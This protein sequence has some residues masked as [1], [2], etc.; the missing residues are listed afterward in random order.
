MEMLDEYLT[1]QK[2]DSDAKSFSQD[3]FIEMMYKMGQRNIIL[4]SQIIAGDMA[5]ILYVASIM[6]ADDTCYKWMQNEEPQLS[7][8][9]FDRLSLNYLYNKL[10]EM[11]DG[12]YYNTL[13]NVLITSG[14]LQEDV[15]QQCLTAF[16]QGQF[17]LCACGLLTIIEG[18]LAKYAQSSNTRLSSLFKKIEEKVNQCQN[19]EQILTAANIKGYIELLTTKSDFQSGMEPDELN[20]HWIL[21][22]RSQ[23]N[24]GKADCL[25]LLITLSLILEVSH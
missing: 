5:E 9:D 23:R 16:E 15:I 3:E 12:L 19:R 8:E 13:K 4:P 10:Y 6:F 21:H 17:F 18:I 25:R 22:G 14:E 7:K 1:Q 11:H 2:S 24:I 20:R